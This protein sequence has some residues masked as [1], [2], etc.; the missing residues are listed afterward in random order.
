[1]PR[2]P[3]L[4][5]T[6]L[7]T[8]HR[9]V[10]KILRMKCDA[11][12]LSAALQA[13]SSAGHSNRNPSPGGRARA[14]AND[15]RGKPFPGREQPDRGSVFSEAQPESA[16]TGDR[17]LSDQPGRWHEASRPQPQCQQALEPA[18]KPDGGFG[19]IEGQKLTFSLG[20]PPRA[21]A[22]ASAS[23]KPDFIVTLAVQHQLRSFAGAVVKPGDKPGMLF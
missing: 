7:R 1:M 20:F 21:P 12:A 11:R 4:E 22:I 13:P 3:A 9:P 19:G 5:R 8:P 16:G 10:L 14:P 6:G 18:S 17:V 15:R 23:R 2:K